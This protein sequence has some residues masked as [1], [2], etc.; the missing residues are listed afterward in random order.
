MSG[1]ERSEIIYDEGWQSARDESESVYRGSGTPADGIPSETPVDETPAA[2]SADKGTLPILISVQ[3]ILCL[4]AA[5]ALLIMDAM[6]SEAYRSFMTYYRVEMNKPVISQELFESL[7]PAK[8]AG[9]SAVTTQ[10]S[11]DEPVLR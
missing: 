4:I 8:L 1:H 11:P 2:E 10:A 3:L 6:D 9:S 5:A 7:S